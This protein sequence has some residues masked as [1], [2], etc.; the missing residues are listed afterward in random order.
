MSGDRASADA[1][2]EAA[3]RYAAFISYRHTEPDRTWAKW[4]H[5]ALE[6]YRT[7]KYLAARRRASGGYS[8]TRRSWPPTPT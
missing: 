2:A 8:G 6:T 1:D 5:R 7:P 4:L 3:P